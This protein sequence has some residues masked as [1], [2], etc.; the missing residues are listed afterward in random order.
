[1]WPFTSWAKSQAD[2]K[3]N[4]KYHGLTTRSTK[5]AILGASKCVIGVTLEPGQTIRSN[6]V[7]HLGGILSEKASEGQSISLL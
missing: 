3:V 4:R 2:R 7:N 1:M 6:F 5:I